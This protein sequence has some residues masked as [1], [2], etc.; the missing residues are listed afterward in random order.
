M[1]CSDADE[2]LEPA[3]GSGDHD[4][5]FGEFEEGF[6]DVAPGSPGEQPPTEG[7]QETSDFESEGFADFSAAPAPPAAAPAQRPTAEAADLLSLAPPAFLDAAAAL[8]RG[9]VP[10]LSAPLGAL[11][12]LASLSKKFPQLKPPAASSATPAQGSAALRWQGSP[13][14]A[15]VLH[16]LVRCRHVAWR[17]V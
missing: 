11:P 16:R 3:W 7:V 14:E 15:R 6:A 9:F 1:G 2:Q 10:D 12:D 4:D 13:A 8:L 5:D 17:H